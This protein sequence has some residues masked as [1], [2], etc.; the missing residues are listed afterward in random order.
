MDV[1]SDGPWAG[2][3]LDALSGRVLEYLVGH[4]PAGSLTVAA[5]VGASREEVE[6]ALRSLEDA[7]LVI[8]IAG[9][10]PR[11]KADPPRSSL[12]SLLARR[13]AE[14]AQAE[15][16]MEQLHE[17]YDFA[18][19]P[20]APHLVEVLEDTEEVTARYAHL[21]KASTQ[22]VLHLAKPPYVTGPAGA[23]SHGDAAQPE[24]REG[25][26][27]R[28]VYDTEGFT[29]TVSLETA[30]RGSARGGEFRLSSRLPVKL[31]LFDRT[32]ALLP[33]HD[34]RPSAGSIEVRSPALIDALAALFEAIWKHAVPVSL[35][36][37]QD[38][39]APR[40]TRETTRI[41][42]R[43]QAIL[44]LMATGM[45]DDAIARVLNISRRTVQKHVSEAGSALGART[46]FQIALRA[47]E[48]GWLPLEAPNS[49][50]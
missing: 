42:E 41:D 19:R 9:R 16:Y 8:P 17:I 21:L 11:W 20:Q 18:A 48:R 47:A 4:A 28:S 12:G 15:L 37:R 30:L 33:L 32:A 6:T 7:L 24:F 14:L 23:S 13:R 46:R 35:E 45:K 25:I 39:P 40:Q 49:N 43:T 26:R 36:S 22:E 34:D 10:P 38:W 1:T 50:D 44:D 29:D 5:A 2:I 31:V 3:G 27:L